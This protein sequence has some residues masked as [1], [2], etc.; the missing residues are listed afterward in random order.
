ML[1]IQVHPDMFAVGKVDRRPACRRENE[2]AIRADDADLNDGIIEQFLIALD[3]VRKGFRV[4][5]PGLAQLEQHE[6]TARESQFGM[7]GKGQA[8]RRGLFPKLRFRDRFRIDVIPADSTP[9]RTKHTGE[10][11][12]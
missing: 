12:E 2:R 11:Q 10:Q 4:G 7:F 3:G 8:E 9:Q 6:F 5:Q 1:R